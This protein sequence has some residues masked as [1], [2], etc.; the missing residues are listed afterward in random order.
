MEKLSANLQLVENDKDLTTRASALSEKLATHIA[1]E[2][3]IRLDR[4]YIEE[5]GKFN[6][7]NLGRCGD[8]EEEE[9]ILSLEEEI[10]TLY[11]EIS[12]LSA[13]SAD[14]QFR[15]PVTRALQARHGEF[16]TASEKQLDYVSF[17]DS[18]EVRTL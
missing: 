5:V 8:E 2:V 7:R 4:L 13:M 12:V 6:S 3:K 17:P 15:T 11:S 14:Q 1:E 9:Q 16:H 18:I 10:N